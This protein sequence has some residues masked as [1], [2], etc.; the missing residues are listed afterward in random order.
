MSFVKKNYGNPTVVFDGY[1]ESSTKD[2]T[3]RRRRKG[4]QG[5]E[6]QFNGS[7]TLMTLKELFLSN[8]KDKARV[9]KLIGEALEEINCS[10]HVIRA[11][12]DLL[13]CLKAV[14]LAEL[15]PVTLVGDDTDLIVLLLHHSDVNSHEI[16]VVSQQRSSKRHVWPI[17]TIKKQLPKNVHENILFLHSFLGCDTVSR[18]HGIGK[19]IGMKKLANSKEIDE[20]AKVFGENSMTQIDVAQAGKKAFMV[21]YGAQ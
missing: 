13:I 4:I 2:M 10:V 9:I 11:D 18:L 16:T 6:V 19:G 8:K 5:V 17:N 21:L 14:E 20:I 7:T 15:S 12:A 1:E 3:H